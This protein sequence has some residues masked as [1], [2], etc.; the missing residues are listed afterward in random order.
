MNEVDITQAY[1]Y[2]AGGKLTVSPSLVLR[3]SIGDEVRCRTGGF[4]GT[5]RGDLARME[6]YFG[7][8]LLY[9]ED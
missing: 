1:G 3:L 9:V 7:M 5:I 2:D 4:S 8:T 6:S